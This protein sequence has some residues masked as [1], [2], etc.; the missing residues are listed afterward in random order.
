[1]N[2]Q[3]SCNAIISNGKNRGKI[4][5]RKNC[6]IFGHDRFHDGKARCRQIL[7]AGKNTGE[8][9]GRKECYIHPNIADFLE[10]SH[11]F[12]EAILDYEFVKKLIKNYKFCNIPCENEQY[13]A[14]KTLSEFMKIVIDINE[15]YP[16]KTRML[17]IIYLIK[18][19]DTPKMILFRLSNKRFNDVVYQ[20]LEEFSNDPD[21]T[22]SAYIKR[23]FES[24]KKYLHKSKNRI[25]LLRNYI[26]ARSC[27]I[28]LYN[29][30]KHKINDETPTSVYYT[31]L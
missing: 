18:L 13:E 17:L 23:H 11:H 9:C 21:Y 6:T 14:Y 1:M 25:V 16:L 31:I 10:L 19:L 24:N 12:R 30:K 8:E 20:K 4:C 15:E 22:F 7:K 3:N 5:R 27:F 26:L 29:S 28:K 2:T